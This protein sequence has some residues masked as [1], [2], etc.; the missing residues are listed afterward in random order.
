MYIAGIGLARGY[1]NNPELTN[2]KF[3]RGWHP[4]PIRNYKAPAGHPIK[5]AHSPTHPLTH[6]PLYKTGDLACWL[7][8]GKIEFLGRIDHQVKVR[9]YRIELGEIETQLLAHTGVKEAVVI[10]LEDKGQNKHLCAYI[11]PAAPSLHTSQLR[12]YLSNKLPAYMLP[13]YFI[14]LDKIPLTPNGKVDRKALAQYEM[15]AEG[16]PDAPG[17]ETERKLMEVWANVLMVDKDKIGANDNFFAL[18]GHSLNATVMISKIHKSLQVKV[19]LTQV[20]ITPTIRQLAEYIKESTKEQYTAVEPVEK[21]DFYLLSPAQK[22]LYILQQM[23]PGS[24]A[25][26]MPQYIPLDQE[27]DK[28]KLQDTFKKLIMRHESLRTSFHMIN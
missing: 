6:S 28:E 11:V 26:N 16:T 7:P 17:N 12:D 13:A 4:Q 18:G 22:R 8:D 19:P 23:V 15:K 20:F 5:I 14:Q 1:L 2:S 24:T 9:G 3:Q 25:Y 21:K 10:D 27:P